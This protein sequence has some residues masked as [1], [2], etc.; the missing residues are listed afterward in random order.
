MTDNNFWQFQ[1][2]MVDAPM[3]L[4]Q[5]QQSQAQPINHTQQ[6]QQQQWTEDDKRRWSHNFGDFDMDANTNKLF[7]K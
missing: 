4:A 6:Q 1:P 7:C 3:M 2:T 5:Q